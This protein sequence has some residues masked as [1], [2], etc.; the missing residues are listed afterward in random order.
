MSVCRWSSDDYGCD[1]YI[2][3]AADG[4][5]CHVATKK[6]DWVPPE[7]TTMKELLLLAGKIDSEEWQ[8]RSSRYHDALDAAPMSAVESAYAGQSWTG[9]SEEELW[10]LVLCLHA[11]GCRVPRSVLQAAQT[12]AKAGESGGQAAL[13]G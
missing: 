2:Y 12:L 1:L 8:N 11:S 3:S 7:G 10:P 9:L 6:Y 4:Y 5:S 13:P